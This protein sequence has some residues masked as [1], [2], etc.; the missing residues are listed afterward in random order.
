MRVSNKKQEIM[1]VLIIANVFGNIVVFR[2]MNVV[3]HD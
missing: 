2:D 1:K 3:E